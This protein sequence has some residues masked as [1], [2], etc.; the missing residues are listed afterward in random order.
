MRGLPF[1]WPHVTE[2]NGRAARLPCIRSGATGPKGRGV[3]RNPLLTAAARRPKTPG[4]TPTP[5]P[6]RPDQSP[7]ARGG[8]GGRAA[9][10]GPY[11]PPADATAPGGRS[12]GKA[13]QGAAAARKGR[14]ARGTRRGREMRKAPGGERQGR[15]PP[16]GGRRRRRPGQSAP[17]HEAEGPPKSIWRPEAGA[18]P[19][20][21]AAG[22][23]GRPRSD[24][25]PPKAGG[26]G[27]RRG[28]LAAVPEGQPKPP[29]RPEEGRIGARSGPFSGVLNAA[30]HH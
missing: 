19:A 14:A 13:P 27:S 24:G 9:T 2:G 6:R 21:G 30:A 26:R 17:S 3:K 10:G 11:G 1:F 18:P 4:N 12:K 15:P 28:T 25:Q 7:N 8:G 16:Q 22:G 29:K 5:Q 23:A 20:G